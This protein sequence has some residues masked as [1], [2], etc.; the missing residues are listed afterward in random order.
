MLNSLHVGCSGQSLVISA[1][2]PL[3]VGY[4]PQLKQQIKSLDKTFI[5]GSRAFKVANVNIPLESSPPV[6]VIINS[7]SVPICKRFHA[8]R[9][10]S[11]KLST[12]WVYQSTIF[13]ARVRKPPWI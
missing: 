6:F 5:W 10:N 3:K 11:A 9:A 2:F 1:K 8:R 12:F 4:M 7:S 13:D